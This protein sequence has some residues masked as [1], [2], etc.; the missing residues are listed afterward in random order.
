[1]NEA[2]P[3]FAAFGAGLL[4]MGFLSIALF[5]LRFWRRTR[6]RLFASFALAFLLMA[7]NQAIPVLFSV[8][9]EEQAGIYLFRLAAFAVICAAVI[10]LRRA[11]P[12]LP[13]SFRVPWVPLLPAVGV[14]F[15]L[16]LI[17][18]LPVGVWLGFAAWMAVGVLVYL[19]YGL[20]HS[21]L[22]G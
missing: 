1:M 5:F 16:W 21:R 17:W 13:R 9:S 2:S 12:E 20:R 22:A 4:A 7:F 19:G 14:V 18:G 3:A 8:P 10:I 6:D 15:C 11:R